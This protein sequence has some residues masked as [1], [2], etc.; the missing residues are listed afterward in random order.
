MQ[1]VGLYIPGG[2]AAYPS[3]RADELHPRQDRGRG[4]DSHDHPGLGRRGQPRHPR[5]G[6]GRGR[7]PGVPRRRRAGR[8][9]PGLRYGD[10]PAGGQDRRPRQRLCRG[11]KAPGVRPGGYRHDR[12]P[13]R[14][15]HRRGRERGPR[16]ACR[17]HALPGRARQARHGHTHNRQRAPSRKR[18][19]RSSRPSSRSCP[20]RTSRARP[21]RQ[22]A[23]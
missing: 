12:R 2:T 20:G 17:G 13:E 10:H 15:T 3:S 14:D 16:L 19:P 6:E 4:R 5:G 22:T 21:W 9:G 18:P 11:G 7:G 1:R 23:R 8:R